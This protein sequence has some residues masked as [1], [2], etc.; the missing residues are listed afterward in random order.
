[1]LNHEWIIEVL[2]DIISYAEKNKLAHTEIEVTN[3][4]IAIE[5]ELGM[6]LPSSSKSTVSLR[7]VFDVTQ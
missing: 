6:R 1:M 5:S 7:E 3:V 2:K 4:L